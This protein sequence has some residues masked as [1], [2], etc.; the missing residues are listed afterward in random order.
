MP[1]KLKPLKK[2]QAK[3]IQPGST[4]AVQAPLFQRDWMFDPFPSVLRKQSDIGTLLGEP[5]DIGLDFEYE[6]ESGKATVLGL[7]TAKHALG[8]PW[9]EAFAGD[10]IANM[11]RAGRRLVGHNVIGADKPVLYESLGIQTNVHQWH[12]TMIEHYLLNSDWCKAPQKSEDEMD[13]GAM[14]FM[15]LWHMAT[16]YLDVPNWKRCSGN[17]CRGI[18]CP[19]HDVFGYCAIDAWAGL[20]GHLEMQKEMDKRPKLRSLYEDLLELGEVCHEMQVRGVKPDLAYID[21][22]ENKANALKERLFPRRIE[23]D[24]TIWDPFNP[25]APE[26]IVAWFAQHNITLE[27]SEKTVIQKQLQKLADVHKF[28][29]DRDGKFTTD[30]LQAAE[31]MLPGPLKTLLNL[32]LYKDSGKG[33]KAWFDPKYRDK[34]GMMHPRFNYTGASTGRLSSS[35][36]NFQNVPVRGFGA[37]VRGGVVPRDPSLDWLKADQSQLELRMCLYLAGVDPSIIGEDA[38]VWLV[39]NSGGL[40]ARAAEL[41]SSTPRFVAKSVSHGGDYMEGLKLLSPSDLMKDNIKKEIECGA[42]RVYLKK[43]MPG[44]KKD[45]TFRGRIV[46]FTGA[47]L[48]ERLFGDKSRENRKKALEI[49]EDVFFA[50]FPMIRE[51]H[52]R[53]TEMIEDSGVVESPTGRFLRLYGTPEEDCKIAAAFLGQGVSADHVQAIMLRYKREMNIIPTLQVHDELDFE[54]DK[55]WSNDRAREFLAFMGEETKRLP[56]FKCAFKGYR[57]Q[58]WLEEDEDTAHIPGVLKRII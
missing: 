12:D 18:I 2:K 17:D 48:A 54:I 24:V 15:S 14:G 51:W 13:G 55:A 9:D 25:K 8:V 58:C 57:G 16:T 52:Q 20:A 36:P 30:F 39:E 10:H 42:L 44:L 53:V 32:Y 7:A 21:D 29:T 37:L 47:N 5:G 26:Q 35:G 22:L 50:R 28:Q 34:W 33:L 6:I 45:W 4:E 31:D 38:F 40:F 27:S 23:A 43:Y 19:R 46:A 3:I 11:L 41:N 56:D 49:Q 1:A